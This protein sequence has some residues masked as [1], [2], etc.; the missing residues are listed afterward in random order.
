MNRFQRTSLR[1]L[2][3]AGLTLTFAVAA[4]A[5]QR[6][7]NRPVTT[8]R[9]AATFDVSGVFGGV[10]GGNVLIGGNAFRLAPSPQVYVIGVGLVDLDRLPIGSRV[11]ATGTLA[12]ETGTIR[13]LIARP[14]SELSQAS[15]DASSR[16]RVR[17]TSSGE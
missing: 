7:R 11:F 1:G 9:P 3:I 12:G 4:Q 2:A 17:D 14:A 8:R 13:S 5:D 16:V 15:G 10:L 6:S